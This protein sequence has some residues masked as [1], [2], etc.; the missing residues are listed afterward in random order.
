MDIV[1]RVIRNL[2]KE[3][4]LSRARALLSIFG[5]DYPHLML[6]LEI[7]AGNYEIAL[8]IYENLPDKLKGEYRSTMEEIRKVVETR[9][10]REDFKDAVTEY[11]KG[12]YQGTIALLEGITKN[13]PELVEAIALKYET[14][15]KRGDISRAKEIEKIL[16][17]FDASHPTL[18][19][20][21][22]SKTSVKDFSLL[23]MSITIAVL[24]V[25]IALLFAKLTNLSNIKAGVTAELKTE[26]KKE[27]SAQISPLYNKI[28]G[29][30]KD[31]EVKAEE[32]IEK[33]NKLYEK[34]SSIEKLQKSMKE[35]IEANLNHQS[36]EEE[37]RATSIE[38]MISKADEVLKDV[39]LVLKKLDSLGEG[40]LTLQSSI[41][42]LNSYVKKYSKLS[43]PLK[44]VLVP[45]EMVYKPSSE[46]D[47]AKIYWLAGYIMYLRNQYSDA[48]DLFKKALKIIN[49][50]YPHAYFHDDC[51]YYLGL[52]Y[53]M[54]TKYE[55]ARKYFELLKR[56]F[57][58]SQY[59]DDAELFIKSIPGGE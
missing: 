11:F 15:M 2:I 32:N 16:K 48:I 50:L 17:S 23:V 53:Y 6:E 49:A 44:S 18:T 39:N 41:T 24:I 19:E 55:I 10:Y 26:V 36:E 35:S 3:G 56:E 4:K 21:K 38:A 45:G 54:E 43:P 22:P 58:Y 31:L 33:T 57:P 13:Y 8:N 46:L 25:I 5:E 30:K 7:A 52:S 14:Y 12:N 59:I 42:K 34:L 47:K 40:V 1:E 9:G 37:A 51:V 29:V 27:L 20:S 28:E